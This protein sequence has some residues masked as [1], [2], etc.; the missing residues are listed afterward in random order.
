MRNPNGYGSVV[1]LSGKR[2]RPYMVRKTVGWNEKGYPAYR[3]LGYYETREDGIIA[4][5]QFNKDGYNLMGAKMTVKELF[6]KW[7]AEK[8]KTLIGNPHASALESTFKNLYTG[9]FNTSIKDIRIY[10]IQS[11]IDTAPSIAAKSKVKNIWYHLERFAI[12]LDLQVRIFY[13]LLRTPPQG[14]ANREIFLDEEIQKTWD[15]YNEIKSGREAHEFVTEYIDT[16]LIFLYTGF[17]LRELLDMKKE[18]ID[19]K[20]KTFRGGIKTDAGK[21]RIVPIHSKIYDLVEERVNKNDSEYFIEE[22]SATLLSATYRV[23]W[24]KILDLL[25][26]KKTPHE[27][28]HTFASKLDSAGANKKCIDLLMGH[29]SKDVGYKVYTHKSLDE[30]RD[31]IELL[32]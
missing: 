27:A 16:V 32:D 9:I 23:R 25:N 8:A 2:R 28:R 14:K 21:D 15:L 13:T 30:L 31:T 4:L 24:H 26:I 6:D 7:Y 10:H 3:I 11:I 5:A 17:R 22:G 20:A 1:K 29:T 12:E 18:A 19:L